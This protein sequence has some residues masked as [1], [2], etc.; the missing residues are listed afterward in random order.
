MVEK[1]TIKNCIM[2]ALLIIITPIFAFS[3]C[4]K[5]D[6]GNTNEKK[7]RRLLMV[8]SHGDPETED[9]YRIHYEYD[10]AGRLSGLIT[11]TPSSGSATAWFTYDEHSLSWNYGDYSLKAFI[12][13]S[14]VKWLEPRG[15]YF[16][17]DSNGRIQECV[18]ENSD[19]QFVWD[20]DNIVKLIATCGEVTIKYTKLRGYD[21]VYQ[22]A[23]NPLCVFGGQLNTYKSRDHFVYYTGL[24][25]P[26][27][28]NLPSEMTWIANE[29]YATSYHRQ[30]ILTYEY[31][32][33]SSGY[34]IGAVIRGVYDGG[35]SRS[36][37]QTMTVTWE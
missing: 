31:T 22:E 32:T 19:T 8:E 9:N 34:P 10:D 35:K 30:A 25:G 24:C 21:L 1:I 36:T 20:D 33:D 37:E 29:N 23:F 12:T 3:S 27:S 14:R 16:T 6:D 7:G 11:Y 15:I 13:D 5:D 18:Y 17:Y 28:K 4:S 26:F 2:L